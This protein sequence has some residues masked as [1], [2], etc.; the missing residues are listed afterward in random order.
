MSTMRRSI[1]LLSMLVVVLGVTAA[2]CRPAASP[3]C[4]N[5]QVRLLHD[6]TYLIGSADF[7]D[8]D[9]S[10]SVSSYRWLVNSTPSISDTLAECWRLYI[11]VRCAGVNVASPA[12]SQN[13][14]YSA[15]R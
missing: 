10:E 14:A 11:D 13:R 6:Y 7:N 4:S 3:T 1:L 9:G 15:G 12:L 2:W 5:A 8:P